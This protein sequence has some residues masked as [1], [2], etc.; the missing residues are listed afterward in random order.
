M[1]GDLVVVSLYWNRRQFSEQSEMEWREAD[2]DREADLQLLRSCNC[3]DIIFAPT[4]DTV[5]PTY[6][7]MIT[8]SIRMAE[9][10]EA[11]ARPEYFP[12]VCTLMAK[13]AP[14]I[15]P[16]AMVMGQ[17]SYQKCLIVEQVMREMLMMPDFT[18]DLV[19]T[20][21]HELGFP[22][23]YRIKGLSPLEQQAAASL[24]A[25]LKAISELYTAGRFVWSDLKPVGEAQ[26]HSMVTVYY[27]ELVDP[28]DLSTLE[29][30]DPAQGAMVMMAAK[31]GATRLIDNI[32]LAP[33]NPTSLLDRWWRR[34]SLK[35]QLKILY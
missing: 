25:C 34:R 29:W 3:V 4:S 15:R 17:P 19:P 14:L 21:R 26:L 11:E 30:V 13:L 22:Y 35:Q 6:N 31:V 33:Q 10:W 32:F 9:G 12:G 2:P 16:H 24:Y 28:N 8:V 7:D 23:S 27:L 20:V 18:V 1:L 5:Y